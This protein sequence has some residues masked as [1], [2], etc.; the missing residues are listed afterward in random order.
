ME[1]RKSKTDPRGLD[2]WELARQTGFH[3]ETL[4]AWARRGRIPGRNYGG[5]VGYRF[6]L[7]LVRR[8]LD[9]RFKS[10]AEREAAL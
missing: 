2:V 9:R 7:E 1:S 5:S 10:K 8:A 3:A 4:R 6:C